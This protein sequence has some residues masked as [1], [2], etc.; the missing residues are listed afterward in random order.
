MY[1]SPTVPFKGQGERPMT[2]RDPEGDRQAPVVSARAQKRV[3]LRFDGFG[4]QVS[5]HRRG[6]MA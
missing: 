5:N 6:A 2:S 4:W 3:T 1:S